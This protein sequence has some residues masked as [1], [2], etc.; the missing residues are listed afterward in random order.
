MTIGR[1]SIQRKLL[2]YP[3]HSTDARSLTP[4]SKDGVV[5][6]YARKVDSPKNVWLMLH[7]NG[8]QAADRVYA[9]PRFSAD[10]SVFIMEY[11][12]YGNREGAPSKASLN[13]AAKQAYLFLRESYPNIP[14]CVIGESIGSGPASSLANLNIPPDKL[15][16]V[17]PFDKLSLVAKEHFP[18]ILVS[19]ILRDNWDNIDALAKYNKSV[20]IFGAEGDVV[21][22]VQHARALAASIPSSKFVL[23]D[24]GHNDWAHSEKVRIRNP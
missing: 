1:A 15:V 21:I 24:G 20:D 6:G 11:P 19:L 16:L 8:G 14:I 18:S 12:G 2:F 17:T 7:G 3:T 5:I 23:I 4:W 10:D 9:I 13:E 22:P